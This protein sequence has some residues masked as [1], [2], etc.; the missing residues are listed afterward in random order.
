V[1]FIC[2]YLFTGYSGCC[3]QSSV[4]LDRGIMAGIL[5]KPDPR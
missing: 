2:V 3:S 4:L 5:A 1:Y